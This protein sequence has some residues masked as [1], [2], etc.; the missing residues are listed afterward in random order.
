MPRAEVIG[1]IGTPQTSPQAYL[2]VF[3]TRPAR[4]RRPPGAL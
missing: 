2:E 1:A 4:P 3:F